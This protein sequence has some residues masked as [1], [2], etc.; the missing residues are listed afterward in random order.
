M[1]LRKLQG[2]FAVAQLHADAAVPDW[3]AGPGL[4]AMVRTEDEL[5]VV[6]DQTRVPPTVTAQRDWACFRSIGPFAFD[7]AGIVAALVSP[8]SAAGIGVFV[9]CTFD[10]EHILCPAPDFDRARALLITQ[11]HTFV[12]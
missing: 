5:T 7:E 12:D 8:I 1:K 10:G 9:L 4:S 11:G 2:R 3:F 6:C